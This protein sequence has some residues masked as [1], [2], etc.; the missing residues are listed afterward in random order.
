MV[1]TAAVYLTATKRPRSWWARRGDAKKIPIRMRVDTKRTAVS[2]KKADACGW[3]DSWRKNTLHPPT[4][5]NKKENDKD[6]AQA[7]PTEKTPAVG[8]S[9]GETRSNFTNEKEV[10]ITVQRWDVLNNNET[11]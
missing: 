5:K 10:A 9:V 8:H 11:T 4:N 2:S 7:R 3:T 1:T 6:G